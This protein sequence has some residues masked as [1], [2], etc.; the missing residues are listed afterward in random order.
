MKKF[1]VGDKVRVIVT[2]HAQSKGSEGVVDMLSEFRNSYRVD[3]PDNGCTWFAIHELELVETPQKEFE[4]GDQVKIVEAGDRFNQEGKLLYVFYSTVEQTD[5][6]TVDVDGKW[7]FVHLDDLELIEDKLLMKDDITST[8]PAMAIRNRWCSQIMEGRP[9]LTDPT[10]SEYAYDRVDS[11]SDQLDVAAEE[12]RDKQERIRELE[13][14]IKSSKTY[15]ELKRLSKEAMQSGDMSLA[16]KLYN[17]AAE[18]E[19]AV[20]ENALIEGD[21]ELS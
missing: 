7:C 21:Y 9:K 14:V 18:R 16:V 5:V 11:L 2:E 3:F 1:K 12:C 8:E 4:V 6:S 19:C 17:K 13:R 15:N 10:T 20:Y